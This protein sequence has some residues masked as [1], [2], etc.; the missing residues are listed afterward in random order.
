MRATEVPLAEGVACE[1]AY[2]VVIDGE[3]KPVLCRWFV[4][5]PHPEGDWECRVEVTW[6]DGRVR[7]IAARGVDSTQALMLGFSLIA[8]DFL[9]SDAPVYWF[10]ANDDLSLPSFTVF[11]EDVAARKARFEGR[12]KDVPPATSKC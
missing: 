6:P 8:S 12:D 2:Q 1:R 7:R 5:Q 9:V 10:E 3:P 11:A 4:P